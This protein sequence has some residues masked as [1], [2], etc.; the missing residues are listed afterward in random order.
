MQTLNSVSPSAR[1]IDITANTGMQPS[2]AAVKV[3]PIACA[4]SGY[5]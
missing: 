4:Q 5:L 1:T 2:D 3:H